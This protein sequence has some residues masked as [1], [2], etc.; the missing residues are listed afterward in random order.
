V[1]R[2]TGGRA[3]LHDN[4][5]TYSF[6]APVSFLKNGKSV[7]DSYREISKCLIAGFKMLDIELSFPEYK[8]IS[9]KGGYCMSLST[10]SDLSYKGKKFIGSAQLRKNEYILQHGS[11]IIN[12]NKHLLTELFGIETCFDNFISL[13]EINSEITNIE[14]VLNCLKAGFEEKLSLI[15]EENKD[16]TKK[17]LKKSLLLE[18]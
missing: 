14:Y 16:L 17:I 9:P 15:F 2:P 1:K 18:D 11:I 3:L 12:I 10:G 7:M 5:I 8:K 4:E 13:N 6:I